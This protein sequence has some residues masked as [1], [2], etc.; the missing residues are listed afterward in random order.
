M[1]SEPC[2]APAFCPEVAA[3]WNRLQEAFRSFF[4]KNKPVLLLYFHMELKYSFSEYTLQ[5]LKAQHWWA[6][7]SITVWGAGKH[8]SN[9]LL[10]Q[11]STASSM[12]AAEKQ[13]KSWYRLKLWSQSQLKRVLNIFPSISYTSCSTISFL[14]E[15]LGLL[16]YLPT[17][18]ACVKPSRDQCSSLHR[19][20]CKDTLPK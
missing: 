1:S 10:G 7:A 14:W 13:K 17:T 6:L 8:F 18:T 19:R 15:A 5:Q 11:G 2:T 12:E 9:P 3:L 16:L 4:W 20:A